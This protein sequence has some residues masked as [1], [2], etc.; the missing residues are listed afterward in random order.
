MIYECKDCK[1]SFDLTFFEELYKWPIKCIK[2]KSENVN[3][4]YCGNMSKIQGL[5]NGKI[6]LIVS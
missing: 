2:C 6:K 1:E 5:N 3:Y 4:G